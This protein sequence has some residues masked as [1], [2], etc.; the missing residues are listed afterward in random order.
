MKIVRLIVLAMLPVV[1][2]AQSAPY[3]ISGK[4]T[5]LNKQT[6]VYM[7]H[8]SGKTETLDSTVVKNGAFEFKGQVTD[9]FKATLVVDHTG[10]GIRNIM[11]PD[12]LEYYVEKGHITIVG[13]DSISKAIIS[14]SVINTENKK[15]VALIT[16]VL[17][18][19]N[20]LMGEYSAATAEERSS[21]EFQDGLEE[22]YNVLNDELIGLDTK[23][24]QANPN[25]FISLYTVI[26]IAG[27]PTAEIASVET[28][29]N[30][31]S[32]QLKN[33]VSGKDFSSRIATLKLVSIG[34]VAQDFTQMN[35]ENKAVKLSDFKGK[36]VLLDFWASWCGP[37]RAENPNVVKVYNQYKDKNFT[38]L[39][40]SLDK[41]NGRT[42]W[43]AAIEKDQLTWNHVSDLK[44]WANEAAQ[45][46]AIRSIPQN[47]LISPEGII[48]AKNL[49]GEAL[50][51]KLD[52]IMK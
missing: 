16:P 34:A 32:P 19:Q 42:A 9:P 36:Y 46:Y 44:G 10:K 7:I 51:A 33:S 20:V 22:R 21:K 47:F 24:I 48:I 8:R 13:T 41:E 39:G 1:A 18:K 49:R 30:G 6:Q 28:L 45:L 5:K 43:L 52:E 11:A 31:L 35:T 27:A 14:G 25:S 2:V 26:S 40:V 29:F 4:L 50:Q 15:H 23:F 37:C 12:L 17:I 38:V 3:V